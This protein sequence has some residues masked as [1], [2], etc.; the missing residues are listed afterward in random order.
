MTRDANMKPSVFERHLQTGIQLILVGLLGWAGLKLVT[1]GEDNAV[2]RE[3]IAYQG[4]Q[5]ISLRRDIRE[6]SNLYQRK[7]AAE[8]RANEVNERF[9]A[10]DQ[11][12]SALEE[13]R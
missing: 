1:L 2:L 4:E 6:W 11:R 3:R 10:I 7:S 9:D 5:I 13:A 12:L 8:Q